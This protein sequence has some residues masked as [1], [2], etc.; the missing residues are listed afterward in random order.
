MSTT[1][2]QFSINWEDSKEDIL[3]NSF[4]ILFG[5]SWFYASDMSSGRDYILDV[6]EKNVFNG[7][8]TLIN[9]RVIFADRIL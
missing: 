7:K 9:L 2:Y 4:H 1:P 3:N 8:F 6:E 5:S